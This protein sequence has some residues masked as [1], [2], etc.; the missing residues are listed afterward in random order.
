MITGKAL[1]II[2]GLT[3]KVLDNSGRHREFDL[4]EIF[5]INEDNLS[6][7]FIQQPS[8]YAY[9]AM[10]QANAEHRSGIVEFDK[11]QEEAAADESFRKELSNSNVK[12]TETVIRGLVVRDEEVSKK[13]SRVLESRYDQKLLKAICSALEMRAAMLQS[14]GSHLRHEMEQTGM[15]VKERQFQGAVESVKKVIDE[16][17][18]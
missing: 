14:L 3:I 6:T 5:S 4:S 13:V 8:I 7:E 17:R 11:D 16:K 1:E 15:N 12:Y 10:L 18:K 9:F 2:G